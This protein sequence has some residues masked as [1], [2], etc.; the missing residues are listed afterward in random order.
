MERL[1]RM[2]GGQTKKQTVRQ[3]SPLTYATK[4]M[5]TNNQ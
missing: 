3:T 2:G 5:V 4:E 1:P